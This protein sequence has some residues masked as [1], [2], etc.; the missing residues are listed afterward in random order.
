MWLLRTLPNNVLAYVGIAH[1]FKGANE[2]V[3]AHGVSGVQAVAE[4]C[5]YL[6][7]GAIDRAVV[8]AYDSA[9]EPEAVVYYTAM[10]L[11]GTKAP[12]PFDRDRDGTVLGEGAGALVLETVEAATARGAAIHGEV[13]GSAINSEAEGI[14]A[15]RDD[16]EGVA[17]A[18]R[19]A[20]ADAGREPAEIGMITAHANGTPGS[21]ASEAR[22][23]LEVFGRSGPPVTGFKWSIGH[24]IAASG[25]IESI[26]TLLCLRERRVPGIA[27]LCSLAPECAGLSATA[28][29][30]QPRSG[31][32]L[33]MTRGFAGLNGCLV[34]SAD[35]G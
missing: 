21:D 4:A 34:L 1:G 6:R 15:I 33:V 32:A 27:T 30:Q 9:A 13:L 28:S 26:L 2:N 35:A 11:V 25:A 5:R 19:A 23:I 12:A 22:G 31:L 18:M 17:R 7:D 20:L 29:E 8:V 14:L 3:T 16:G 24:T 10:G